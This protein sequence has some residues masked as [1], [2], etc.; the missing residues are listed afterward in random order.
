MRSL[1]AVLSTSLFVAMALGQGQPRPLAPTG[2]PWQPQ[3]SGTDVQ[4]RGISAVSDK[5]A[6]ASGAKGTV[7][8]TID[9]GT[10]WQ[11]LN[12]VGA[13]ALDFR[14][15]QAFDQNI[16]FVLSIGP[17][18]QSRIYKTA[19]GGKI[20]QRQ[21]T[22][23]D[24]KAFYDCFA[25]WDS[26]HGIALSDSVNGKFP[27]VATSD[28]MSWNPV[29]VKKMPAALPNEGAF[30]ASGTCIATFG[31]NDVWFGTGGP[32]ARVF[33]SSDRGQMWTVSETQVRHGEATQ[34][35]FSLAFWTSKDGIAVGGDYKEPVHGDKT[36]VF[37]HDGGKT[38]APAAQ[39][40]AGYRSAVWAG[41]SQ[42]LMVVGTSGAD[43]SVDGGNTWHHFFSQD[44]NA[45]A[46][47]STVHG[48]TLGW[49][50]GPAGKILMIH[51]DHH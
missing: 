49:A 8:R 26:T 31:K 29:A 19:D 3:T 22:N 9:G 14:D 37:T 17:G 36:A 11:K 30:A 40:P 42:T 34:G 7:L 47:K 12:I 13:E 46:L 20:W 25:F 51:L 6:W 32:A 41:S 1:A 21:F 10:T 16:A 28:G 38:W 33:H 39:P 18:E 43:V 45:L 44:L 5:V 24:P 35:V 50:V 27:L 23:N 48:S 2:D 4:L 15:I